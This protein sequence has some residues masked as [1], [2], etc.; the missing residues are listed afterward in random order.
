[1]SKYREF[2]DSPARIYAIGDIHGCLIELRI[3]LAHLEETQKLAADDLVVFIG[4]YIDRGADSKGVIDRLI[5][6][7]LSHPKYRLSPRKS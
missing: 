4:D 5:Q 2:E 1:M 6:F 7:Q 3:L